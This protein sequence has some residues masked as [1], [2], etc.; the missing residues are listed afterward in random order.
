[1]LALLLPH[2]EAGSGR[3]LLLLHAGIA[4]RTMWREQLEPLAGAG[5]G[6]VQAI[7]A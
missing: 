3:T 6:A 2:D 1:V 4:E 7:R 5:S